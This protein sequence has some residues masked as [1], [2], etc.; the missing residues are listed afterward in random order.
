MISAIENRRSI[1]KY[2]DREVPKELLEKIIRAGI[3]APSSKNRQPWKFIVATGKAK[4]ESL[5]VM[6]RGLEREK[7]EPL[8]T[9]SAQFLGGAEYTLRI[10]AEAP[11]IIYIVNTLGSDVEAAADADTRIFDICNAQSIGAAIENMTLAATELGLGSLWIC[12]TYFA[13]RELCGWLQEDGTLAAALA[14]GYADEVP[15]SRPRKTLDETV[16]WRE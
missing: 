14:V 6:K 4:Q 7:T 9:A 12:D 1:R 16:V 15:A 2:Q 13:Y 8:L 5:E 3:Q 10:M 11:A